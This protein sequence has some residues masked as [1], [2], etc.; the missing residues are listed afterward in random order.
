MFEAMMTQLTQTYIVMCPHWK[1]IW[2]EMF[3]S[4]Q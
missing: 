1:T 2:F 4:L 3:Y